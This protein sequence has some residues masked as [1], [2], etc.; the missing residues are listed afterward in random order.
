MI[1]FNNLG[2]IISQKILIIQKAAYGSSFFMI[3][4]QAPPA[5][6]IKDRM[7]KIEQEINNTTRKIYELKILLYD[8]KIKRNELEKKFL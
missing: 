1:I 2:M 3:S 7:D 5:E 4:K 6:I 8:L